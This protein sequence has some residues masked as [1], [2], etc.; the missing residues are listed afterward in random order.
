MPDMK[1]YRTL[2]S[3]AVLICAAAIY[4]AVAQTPNPVVATKPVYV[5]DTSHQ[6]DPMPQGVLNW[7]AS[8]QFTNAV[9][10]Q[11]QAEFSFSC[12][13][14]AMSVNRTWT[15]NF[16]IITNITEVTNRFLWFRTHSHTKQYTTLTNT[17]WVTNSI[18]PTSVTI[19]STRPSCGCTTVQLSTPFTIPP[20]SNLVFGAKV[21]LM[22][23][24]GTLFKTITVTTDKGTMTLYLRITI[25]EPPAKTADLSDAERAQGVAMSTQD[26]QAIFK[27]DCARCHLDP[28][29]NL[30]GKQLY[31]AVCAVCHEAQHRAT[32]VPDLHNLKVPTNDEFW[33]TWIT[34]GK[35]GTLMAAFAANEG[36]P[37]NDMQI[38]SL[39]AYLDQAIPSYVPP[40][41]PNASNS[42]PTL[43]IVNAPPAK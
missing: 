10:G 11:P 28:G 36:G 26:R 25:E 29:K 17:L 9:Q 39:A 14:V 19:I 12:T 43:P 27:G 42:P 34:Q 40:P 7:N 23:K 6:N 31:D 5:P 3:V 8:S 21:N 30:Y 18:S 38:S 24:N 4:T 41:A 1:R 33:R 37:L 13:N 22:G 15:T 2:F 32:M 16:T 35:P 20:G